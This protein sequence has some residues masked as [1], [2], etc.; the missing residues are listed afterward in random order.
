MIEDI[1]SHLNQYL[2]LLIILLHGFGGLILFRYSQAIQIWFIFSTS[3]A[4]FLWGL[5]HHHLEKNL[6]VKIVFEYLLVSL[7]ATLLLITLVIRA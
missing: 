2:I 4:Y 3:A 1:K 6:T 5:V 7:L